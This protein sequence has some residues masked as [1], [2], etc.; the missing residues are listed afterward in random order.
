EQ[1]S[2]TSQDAAAP[3]P[4]YAPARPAPGSEAWERERVER[5]ARTFRDTLRALEENLAGPGAQGEARPRR[6]RFALDDPAL[7]RPAA[8][9]PAS[10]PAAQ[11]FVQ[12]ERAAPEPESPRVAGSSEPISEFNPAA[13]TGEALL[14][15]GAELP[16]TGSGAPP[17]VVALPVMEEEEPL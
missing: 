14:V 8:P 12:E 11:T 7:T 17:A 10:G 6:Q 3:R 4:V 15:P 16:D 1:E 13:V 2:L 9:Q 5:L